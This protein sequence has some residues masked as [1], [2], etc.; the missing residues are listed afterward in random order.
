MQIGGNVSFGSGDL[1]Q[2]IAGVSWKE[3]W[4]DS[5]AKFKLRDRLID[6]T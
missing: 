1:I 4:W 6:G 3:M 2:R 5:F